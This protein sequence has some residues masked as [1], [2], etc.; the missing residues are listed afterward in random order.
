MCDIGGYTVKSDRPTQI[1]DNAR[2]EVI[3]RVERIQ[4]SQEPINSPNSFPALLEHV[5]HLGMDLRYVI[6]LGD[7][8]LVAMDKNRM[9]Q[10]SPVSGSKIYIGWLPRE[11]LIVP[12]P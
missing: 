2:V 12:A 4:L 11:T 10:S 9:Q 6:R 1:S 7:H 3:V 5:M 8:R